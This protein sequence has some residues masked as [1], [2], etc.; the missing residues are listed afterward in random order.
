MEKKVQKSVKILHD[1]G[2]FLLRNINISA[3]YTHYYN[4]IINICITQK[5]ETFN[6][7]Q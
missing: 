1:F 5:F 3:K 6:L 7:L 4:I 2:G